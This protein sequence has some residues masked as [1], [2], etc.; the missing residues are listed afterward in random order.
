M[1]W[2][3]HVDDSAKGIYDMILCRDLSIPLVLDSRLSDKSIEADY[4]HFKVSTSSMVDWVTYELKTLNTGKIK[5]EESFMNAYA[6][7]IHESEQ[8]HT[9]TK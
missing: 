7:E 4:G 3:C 5:P 1:T 2:N 6:E 9:Y 8:V